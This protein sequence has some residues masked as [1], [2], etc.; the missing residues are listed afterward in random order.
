MSIPKSPPPKYT[1]SRQLIAGADFNNLNDQ[2]N[3]FQQ[4][5]ATGSTQATAAPIDA[6]HVEL[7]TTAGAAGV[8]LPVS[9]PGAM[10]AVLNNSG[11]TITVYGNGTDVVQTSGTTYA[12][13]ATGIT[14]ATLVCDL[15]F[16]IKTG[17][18]QRIITA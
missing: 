8:L 15:F 12:A 4:L 2:L 6:A 13:A 1:S 7:L 10:V 5:T 18:W 11:Q 3:S 14:M 16:C 17:F 9:Y